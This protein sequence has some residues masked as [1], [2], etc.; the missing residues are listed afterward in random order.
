MRNNCSEDS[1][2]LKDT[3]QTILQRLGFESAVMSS[4]ATLCLNN[5]PRPNIDRVSLSSFR[6][7]AILSHK[8]TMTYLPRELHSAKNFIK[9]ILLR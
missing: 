6:P 1:S 9:L 8:S 3:L 2:L 4:A 5:E 7:R